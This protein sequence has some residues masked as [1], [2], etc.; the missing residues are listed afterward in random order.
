MAAV[1]NIVLADGQAAPVNHT[2]VPTKVAPGLVTYHDK[3]NG[4]VAGFPVLT[5]SSRLPD[6][7]SPNYKCSGKVSVPIL[8][9]AA[10]A[11]SGFTPGPT[12]AYRN[13]VET[14]V[15]IPARATLAERKDIYAYG[16]NLLA[17]AVF[18]ALVQ[19]MD[20]PY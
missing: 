9:T 19:D 4:V 12:V 17:H 11:A 3:A 5:I 8:E 16:K 13:L 14:N 18:G 1:A 2:F 6:A 20:A 15:V 7:T 10:T